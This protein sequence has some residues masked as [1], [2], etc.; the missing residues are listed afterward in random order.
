[1][2]QLSLPFGW[3]AFSRDTVRMV[4]HKRDNIHRALLRGWATSN[5]PTMKDWLYVIRHRSD[6]KLMDMYVELLIAKIEYEDATRQKVSL[7]Q[8]WMSMIDREVD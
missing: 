1:M 8:M 6:N 5:A 4:L 2:E 7:K 3:T